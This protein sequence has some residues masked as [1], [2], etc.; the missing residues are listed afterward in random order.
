MEL[1]H[2]MEGRTPLVTNVYVYS[3]ATVLDGACL[4]AGASA[5]SAVTNI[6]AIMATVVTTSATNDAFVGI[7]QVSSAMGSASKE[8]LGM[9]A[10]AHRIDTDGIP[11]RSTTTGGDFMPLCISPEAVY[12][13]T[14][15]SA[16]GA[17]AASYNVMNFTGSATTNDDLDPWGSIIG[18]KNCWL[19]SLATVSGGAATYSGQLRYVTNSVATDSSTKSTAMVTSTDTECITTYQPLWMGGITNAAGNMLGSVALAGS[20]TAAMREGAQIISL[21]ALISHDQAPTHRLRYHIDD[22]LNALTGVKVMQ[23]II[24]TDSYLT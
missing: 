3:A 15:T 9:N 20:A 5:G 16:T 6:G 2:L 13:G 10:A 19:F 18:R 7:T 12:Y 22:G 14:F 1:A 21:D 23:E 11:D 17:A 24:F 4:I 8:N